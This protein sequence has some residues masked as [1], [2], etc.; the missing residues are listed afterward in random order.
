MVEPEEPAHVSAVPATLRQVRV[1]LS[2]PGD[3]AYERQLAREAARELEAEPFLRDRAKLTIVS[4]DDPAAT[5]PIL[6]D[7]TPQESVS[8][9]RP[10]PSECDIVIVILW[11][12]LGTPL[13]DEYRKADGGRYLSGTEWEYEDALKAT[14]RPD[15]LVYR[16]TDKILLD[17]DD[18]DLA[19]KLAQREQIKQFFARFRSPD[20]SLR[21]GITEYD[22]PS[23]FADRL[24]KDLRELVA[25]RL[26]GP[27]QAPS[28]D[29][30]FAPEA[31]VVQP[32]IGP[33]YPG[34]RAFTSDEAAIF[35]GRGREVDA[36]VARLARLLEWATI[37]AGSRVR[38]SRR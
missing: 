27:S 15:I 5:A 10:K 8:R 23:A 30:R 7:R 16:R 12:R 4:W 37:A 32:W 18:P 1:F 22:T 25:A 13:P 28:G 2:S 24:K 17:V 19:A 21:G 9:G 36:L 3:V 11:S 34:L 20:G 6:A 31:V 14:P 38:R 33:P 35:F 26:R 29:A